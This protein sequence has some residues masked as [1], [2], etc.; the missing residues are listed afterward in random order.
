LEIYEAEAR[1]DVLGE[2]SALGSR[3]GETGKAKICWGK[4]K[5]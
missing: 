3:P 5:P 4:I 2:L 1:A